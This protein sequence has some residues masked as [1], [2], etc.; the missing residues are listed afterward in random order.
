MKI[1]G[2]SRICGEELSTRNVVVVLIKGD[3][4]LRK[5]DNTA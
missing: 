5:G 3:P 1:S 2:Y 4:V